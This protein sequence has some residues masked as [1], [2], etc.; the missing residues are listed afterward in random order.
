MNIKGSYYDI[1]NGTHVFRALCELLFVVILCLYV[2]QEIN[3]IIKKILGIL[4]KQQKEEARAE[5][6]KKQKEEKEL[7]NKRKLF[8]EEDLPDFYIPDQEQDQEEN[9]NEAEILA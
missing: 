5:L 1:N 3:Q 2:L 7:R 9:K 8:E 4:T 6:K